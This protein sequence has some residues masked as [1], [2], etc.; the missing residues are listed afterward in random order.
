MTDIVT[1]ADELGLE[2]FA[3][4]GGSGGAPHSLATAARLPE[5]VTRAECNVGPT[6]YGAEGLDYFN[7]MD[8]ENVKELSVGA[9]G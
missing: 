9:G 2:R 4:T 1:I 3:V 7:G 5:R 8:P 6:P